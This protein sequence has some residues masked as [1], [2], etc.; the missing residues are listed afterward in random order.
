MPIDMGGGR[1]G[2]LP[3]CKCI[4]VALDL[5]FG[6]P[7][8]ASRLK[9]PADPTKGCTPSEPQ[10]PTRAVDHNICHRRHMHAILVSEVQQQTGKQV[11]L[12]MPAVLHGA[13]S[14]VLK[15]GERLSS[16]QPPEGCCAS[17]CDQDRWQEDDAPS[18]SAGA[19]SQA[20]CAHHHFLRNTSVIWV[21]HRPQLALCPILHGTMVIC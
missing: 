10:V 12:L 3:S 7:A 20:A 13:I 16:Q 6:C 5:S 2:D 14:N 19:Q 8:A 4:T 1:W 17:F 9:V 21:W 18:R 15:G 11:Q